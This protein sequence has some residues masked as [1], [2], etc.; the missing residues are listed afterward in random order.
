MSIWFSKE[1]GNGVDAFTPS[2]KIQEAFTPLFIAAGSP[3]DFAVF[4]RYDLN[5]NLVTVYFSPAAA[6]LA[7]AFGAIPCERPSSR[8]MSLLVGPQQA[9]FSFFPDRS[10]ERG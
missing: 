5:T 3:E 2:G 7:K 6:L 1:L 10:S 9:L 8:R 4:S